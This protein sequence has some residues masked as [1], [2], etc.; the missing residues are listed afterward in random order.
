[1]SEFFEENEIADKKSIKFLSKPDW[2]ELAKDCVCFA[3]AKGGIIIIGIEN[4][5]DLPPKDQHIDGNW[6]GKI[7]KA[8][9]QLTLNV[10]IYPD[11]KTAINGSEYV[12]I[13][14]PPNRQTIAST[15]NGRYYIRVADDCKPVLPDEMARLASDKS[16]FV[17]ELQT[18]KRIPAD[19]YDISKKNILLSSLSK[20]ARVSDFVKQK[21]DIEM[22]EHYLMIRDRFLTN[23]GILWIGRREDRAGLLYAP[24]IQFIKYDH[25]DNK[26]NKIVWDDYSKNPYELLE[27]VWNEIGD[28]KESIEIPF[29][30]FRKNIPVYEEVIVREL[31]TNA[32]VHRHY[33]MRGEIF[34]NLFPD[35]LE[36]H[37]PGLLPL[38]VTPQNILTQ[39]LRRNEHLAKVFY[40]LGLMEREGSGY[41]KMYEVLLAD[42]KKLPLI[43]EIQDRVKVTVFAQIVD[44]ISI[45]LI[46]KLNEDYSLK[47]TEIIL[48]GLIAQ[49]HGISAKMLIEKLNIPKIERI[50]DLLGN[51]LKNHVVLTKGKTRGTEYYVNPELIRKLGLKG[52]TDLKKIEI[53]R[54]KELLRE[55]LKNYPESRIGE[56]QQRIGAEI[57]LRRIRQALGIMMKDDEVYKI[58]Q[59]KHTKYLLRKST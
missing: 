31:V 30:M 25:K 6:P 33:S 7:H 11:I 23:L 15:S 14:I 57:A 44:P 34:I 12:E 10:A 54:L 20:S 53:H 45:R 42:G 21:S 43:E 52:K 19:L 13:R 39:S 9:T 38:G 22:L 47:G 36:I 18:T 56:I 26:I 46:E 1:M 40:D 41:D 28:W 3:N 24:T 59:L 49:H 37:S 35:R 50:N 58:G 48:V 16:A 55:D 5:G 4:D 17:W 2:D 29:G 32:L 51:L 8:I 27:S